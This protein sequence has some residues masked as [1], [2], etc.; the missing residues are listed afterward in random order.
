MQ[1][2]CRYMRWVSCNW[3]RYEDEYEFCQI[4][5]NLSQCANCHLTLCEKH[6]A[7]EYGCMLCRKCTDEERKHR[8]RPITFQQL[9]NV[10]NQL[11]KILGPDQIKPIRQMFTKF[12]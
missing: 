11:E 9:I 2:N 3:P 10:L 12:S 4:T 7:K 8:D 1:Q 6:I 5:D